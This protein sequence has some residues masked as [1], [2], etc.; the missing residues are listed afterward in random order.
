MRFLARQVASAAL[1][2]RLAGERAL[3]C[4]LVSVFFKHA[5]F[6]QFSQQAGHAGFAAA[7]SS[8]AQRATSVSSVTV[9]FLSF[10]AMSLT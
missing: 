2:K 3:H 1:G 4:G 10:L 9:T 5:L 6:K 7:A 8:R